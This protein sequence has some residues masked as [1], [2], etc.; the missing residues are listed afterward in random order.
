MLTPVPSDPILN[1]LAAGK[2]RIRRGWMRGKYNDGHGRYCALGA[3]GIRFGMC[4]STAEMASAY[5]YRV[6]QLVLN[7]AV[8]EFNDD[9]RVEQRHVLGL[10][11]WA[12][13][14]RRIELRKGGG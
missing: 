7:R 10:F 11:D 1:A 13:E 8:S 2:E 4:T 12:M 3:L 14:L 9:P 5:L 6:T